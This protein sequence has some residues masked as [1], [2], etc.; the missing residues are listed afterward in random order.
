MAVHPD[1]HNLVFVGA[2]GSSPGGG[3]SLQRYDHRSGQIR[4][5]NVWPEVHDGIGPVDLKVRFPWTYPIL[6]SPHDSGVL[7]TAG[8]FVFKSTDQGQSWDPISSDL[9]RNDPEKLAASGGPITKDTSG[10]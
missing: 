7:Y 8:N 4:L 2:V 6:F 5:I 1:D 10:A 3:G 9:T